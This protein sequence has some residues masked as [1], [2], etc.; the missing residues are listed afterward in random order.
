M[1]LS[2]TIGGVSFGAISGA[3]GALQRYAGAPDY[4][5]AVH[6]QPG[7]TGSLVTRMGRASERIICRVRYRGTTAATVLGYLDSDRAAWSGTPV[8][9]TDGSGTWTSC[10]L[11]ECR[12]VRPLTTLGPGKGCFMDVEYV[13]VSFA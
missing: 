6:H 1:A 13:F 2:L 5:L 12:T 9:V 7:A 3:R 10:Y 8:T 4:L 11:D